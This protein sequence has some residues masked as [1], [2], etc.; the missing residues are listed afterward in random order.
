[1]A[2]VYS[3]AVSIS[4]GG[5]TMTV[6]NSS[7]LNENEPLKDT[8]TNILTNNKD[9]IL[10]TFPTNQWIYQWII[11]SELDHNLQSFFD[12]FGVT[13]NENLMNALLNGSPINSLEVGKNYVLSFE[14]Y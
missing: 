14:G 10:E 3:V 13:G 8:I 9:G 1:M 2:M 11:S 7:F 4:D 5:N 6:S 12:A